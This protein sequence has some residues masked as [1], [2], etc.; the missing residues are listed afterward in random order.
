M[1][2]AVGKAWQRQAQY[3]QDYLAALQVSGYERK[4]Q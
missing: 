4:P 3:W 1:I 2:P